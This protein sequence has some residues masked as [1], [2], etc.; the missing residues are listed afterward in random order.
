M[1]PATCSRLACSHQRRHHRRQA[2]EEPDRGGLDLAERDVEAQ[3]RGAEEQDPVD[4]G[5]RQPA[6]APAPTGDGPDARQREG[7]QQQRGQREPRAR[8]ADG[9]DLLVA[10]ADADEHD[11]RRPQEGDH[12]ADDDGDPPTRGGSVQPSAREV[13]SLLGHPVPR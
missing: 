8:E 3:L 11:R 5:S 9:L 7:Q 6:A 4:G 13:C 12:D 2:H 1:M 10:D